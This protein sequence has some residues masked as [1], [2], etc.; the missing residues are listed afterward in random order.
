MIVLD[1]ISDAGNGAGTII[2]EYVIVNNSIKCRS[3]EISNLKLWD[4]VGDQILEKEIRSVHKKQ[5]EEEKLCFIISRLG[6]EGD[7]YTGGVLQSLI[8]NSTKQTY[9]VINFNDWGK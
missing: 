3:G 6:N 7:Y 1:I 8:N 4:Y 2:E 9:Q 5:D